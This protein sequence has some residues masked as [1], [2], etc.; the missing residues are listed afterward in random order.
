MNNN[1]IKYVVDTNVWLSNLQSLKEVNNLVVTGAVLRELDKLKSSPNRQLAYESRCATRYI[2]ENIDTF[3]I[4]LKDYDAEVVLGSEY[5]NQYADN[6]I[7]ASVIA[8]GYG[9]VISND[10]NVQ[11]KAKGLGITVKELDEVTYDDS[12]GFKKVFMTKSEYN[13]FH[14]NRIDQNEFNLNI[15]EYLIVVDSEETTEDN[16][17]VIQALKW[18]GEFYVHIQEKILKSMYVDEFEARDAYQACAVDSVM[19]N[20]ITILRGKAGTAKTLI[21]VS[22]ALQQLFSNKI[23]KLIVFSNS[24]PTKDAYYHGLVK[25]DLQQKL[26]QST[27]GNILASKLGSYDQVEAL[28]ITEKLVLLP[29]SDIRGYDTT[30]M[31]ALV[32]ITEGQN[33]STPLM[34]LSIQRLGDDGRMIIE[35]DNDT[36]LDLDNVSGLN[37]GMRVASLVFRGESYYGEVELQNIYRSQMA[38]KAQEMMNYIK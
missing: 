15:G 32:L 23:D 11:L 6:R 4:D 34:M 18:D 21:A 35:G 13:E 25:G 20:K 22:Y 19:N 1:Q 36:Q 7:I 38:A 30:G 5:T 3:I 29:M 12:S 2:K 31:N 24:V 26:R 16:E 10:I 33:V 9:G 28:M 8:G 17:V 37:N 14:D 27:I